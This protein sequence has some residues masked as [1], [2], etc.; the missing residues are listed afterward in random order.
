MEILVVAIKQLWP[1]TT[2][3]E[4]TSQQPHLPYAIL[5]KAHLS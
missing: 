2:L 5:R 4:K 1:T 3:N